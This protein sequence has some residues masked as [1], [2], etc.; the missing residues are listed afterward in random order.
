MLARLQQHPDPGPQRLDVGAEEPRLQVCEQ[1][2]HGEQRVGLRGVQPQPGQGVARP[3]LAARLVAI[4]APGPVP[5]DGGGEPIAQVLQVPHH[6]R[7]RH[8]QGL[9]HRLQRH[10]LT[11]LQELVDLVEALGAVH[12]QGSRCFG[13][14][15][16]AG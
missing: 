11:L 15:G 8:P 9:D 4:P 16:C 6:R 7:P 5:D 12:G 13:L 1:L 10:R 2:L 14:G 3:A